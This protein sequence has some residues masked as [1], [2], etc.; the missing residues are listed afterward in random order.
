MVCFH[1][2]TEKRKIQL[3]LISGIEL[4]STLINFKKV[5]KNAS[6]HYNNCPFCNHR[7]IGNKSRTIHMDQGQ[8]ACDNNEEDHPM[9]YDTINELKEHVNPSCGYILHKVIIY[10]AN[11][12]LLYICFKQILCTYSVYCE[13]KSII[14]SCIN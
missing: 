9:Q 12:F 4:D 3:D 8:I 1:C 11:L 7:C 14:V 10:F 5:L 13:W 6:N 2:C